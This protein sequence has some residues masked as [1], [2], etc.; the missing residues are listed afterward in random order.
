[1]GS[2]LRSSELSKA[3]SFSKL[4]T[5]STGS[6]NGFAEDAFLPDLGYITQT[7]RA[8][9]LLGH[10]SIRKLQAWYRSRDTE[11][12]A[13]W[14]KARDANHY[15]TTSPTRPPQLQLDHAPHLPLNHHTSHN[16]TTLPLDPC[17]SHIDHHTTTWHP[18]LIYIIIF[19]EL[20]YMYIYIDV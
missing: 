1:M 13:G 16:A 2:E 5:W 12:G 3:S 17:T 18:H 11:S 10:Y 4:G 7:W 8:W 9:S 6:E 19:T 20:K 15:I 14:S